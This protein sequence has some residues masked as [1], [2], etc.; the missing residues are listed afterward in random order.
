MEGQG[1]WAAAKTD[2]AS[3]PPPTCPEVSGLVEVTPTCLPALRQA[4]GGMAQTVKP[5]EKEKKKFQ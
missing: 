4:G 2:G 5:K 1:K 3:R